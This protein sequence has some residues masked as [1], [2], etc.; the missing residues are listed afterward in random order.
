MN[1]LPQ[2][3]TPYQQHQQQY[4]KKHLLLVQQPYSGQKV[5]YQPPP[6]PPQQQQ[7]QQQYKA[8]RT[9]SSHS[10]PYQPQQQPQQQQQAYA[11]PPTPQSQYM[12]LQQQQPQQYAPMPQ[13]P[14]YHHQQQPQ[15]PMYQHMLQQPQHPQQPLPPQPQ[16]IQ[17]TYALLPQNGA[18]MYSNPHAAQSVPAPQQHYQLPPQSVSQQQI[19]Q[20]RH[21][22]SSSQQHF[23]QNQYIPQ[24]HTSHPVSKKPP[25]PQQQLLQPLQ[26][27]QPLQMMMQ[28][29][30]SPPRMHQHYKQPS[31][32]SKESL[33]TNSNNNNNNNNNTTLTSKQ[34]LE[35][36]LRS[37]FEKVD[38]NK[39]GRISAKELSYALLNFDHTRFHESTIK[40]MLNLFTA[41]KKSDG[42]SSSTSSSSYGSSNKS[43]NFDQ[44]VSL[45]KYLSAYKKL[46]I[47]ADADKSGDI[48]FGEF[49]KILEQIGYKL[50]I[51]LVLHL[52][53]KYTAKSDG[54]L[55]GGGEI[56]RLKFDMFI[57][58]LI[59]LRKL[60]DIFKKYDK[61]L[62]GTA[63]IGFSDFLFE[64]SNMS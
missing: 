24:S 59:Y 33:S 16:Q 40:L 51:D 47:Q 15:P 29:T 20:G 64:I 60:T 6:P 37:V 43:L 58:L 23:D 5:K 53:S 45:W 19:P 13:A 26:P 12:Y 35:I 11:V 25:P 4:P 61:D 27:L 10:V 63:T 39:L 49:Q 46:F 1:D 62:S 2:M 34:K 54:G 42:S 31:N 57:E 52:F 55:G 28:Q 30:D 36:E 32:R 41:Q 21:T 14:I 22:S 9:N 48:S 17:Q 50:D 7:Q 38:T 3:P 8:P 18:M 44:F 56:G